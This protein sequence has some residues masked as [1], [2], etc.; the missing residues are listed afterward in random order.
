MQEPLTKHLLD[1]LQ[2]APSDGFVL[3]GGFALRVKRT[4]LIKGKIRT[5]AESERQEL[6]EA[7]ATSDLDLFL[8]IEIFSNRG[9]GQG[10]RSAIDQLGYSERTPKWQFQKPLSAASR[11]QEMVLDLLARQPE[12]GSDVKVNSMRVGS[13]SGTDLHGLQTIEAFAVEDR[14]ILCN[15]F[16]DGGVVGQVNVAH[17]FAMLNMKV[18]ASHD[19]HRFRNGPWPMRNNQLPPSA[20]HAFDCSLI[21]AMLT[22]P[23]LEDCRDWRLP[24]TIIQLQPK[25]DGRP[26]FFSVETRIQVGWRAEGR[27]YLTTTI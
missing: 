18:R 16:D 20:K 24:I 6:P 9:R 4:H 26:K 21:V 17:P 25:S 11:D 8:R 14:A 15:V 13:R 19:W 1:L 23:E 27:A 12:V 5:L 3:G 22:E 7:R 10:L 2:T